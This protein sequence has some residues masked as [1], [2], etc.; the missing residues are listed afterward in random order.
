MR[1]YSQKHFR[2]WVMVMTAGPKVQRIPGHYGFWLAHHSLTVPRLESDPMDG[3]FWQTIALKITVGKVHF[4]GTGSLFFEIP[5]EGR[6]GI[7]VNRILSNTRAIAD[8]KLGWKT[9]KD[10]WFSYLPMLSTRSLMPATKVSNSDWSIFIRNPRSALV[11][12]SPLTILISCSLVKMSSVLF[13]FTFDL[14]DECC[15]SLPFKKSNTP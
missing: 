14:A 7:N 12:K 1:K 4:W 3:R 15:G 10:T 6:P 2:R 13:R 5:I 9:K 11:R 8:R